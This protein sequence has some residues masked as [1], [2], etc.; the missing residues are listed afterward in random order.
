MSNRKRVLITGGSGLLALNWACAVRDKW[1]V[2]LGIHNHSVQLQGASQTKLELNNLLNLESQL[3]QLSVD[4]IVHT[5]GMT[6]VDLCEN[7]PD[8]AVLVN[9]TMAKNIAIVSKNQKI[10]LIHIST[11]HLFS[12]QNS[13]CNEVEIPQPLNEYAR[14][15]LLAE[16]WVQE[17][18][19]ES[20][21]LRTNFFCWGYAQRQS[22]SDWIIYTLRESKSLSMFDDVFIT[23]ILA[24]S[25]ALL[26]H[27]LVEKDASG[28]FNLVGDQRISKY[29][30]ALKLAKYFELPINN[31]K[32]DKIANAKL[33]A[34]RPHDMSL[35]NNKASQALGKN[36]GNLDEYFSILLQ[37]EIQGRRQELF[38]SVS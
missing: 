32:R 17:A 23:P 22:F 11:D 9:A 28:I 4:L 37:Q 6:S 38:N 33:F 1:D 36:V 31:I 29:E 18:N 12:G 30:F 21:I 8:L 34:Q 13:Y 5:A 7:N 35:N 26:A 3:E 10:R 2:I 19:P 24:D 20:L 16:K 25:L 15:K 27:E 14:S